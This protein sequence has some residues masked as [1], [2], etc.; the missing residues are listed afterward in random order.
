MKNRF[1]RV[2]VVTIIVSI[3]YFVFFIEEVVDSNVHENNNS[4]ESKYLI[5]KIDTLIIKKDSLVGIEKKNQN[6]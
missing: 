4:V 5:N 2:T 1:V 3:F 6:L